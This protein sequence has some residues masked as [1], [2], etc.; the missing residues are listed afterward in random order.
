VHFAVGKHLTIAV[1][2]RGGHAAYILVES[3]EKPTDKSSASLL[4]LARG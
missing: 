4:L 3:V 2:L 1:V